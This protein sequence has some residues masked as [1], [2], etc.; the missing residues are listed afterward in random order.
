LVRNIET[1]VEEKPGE[2][3]PSN[4]ERLDTVT[5]HSE[6]ITMTTR[7]VTNGVLALLFLVVAVL[8]TSSCESKPNAYV[9]PDPVSSNL[10]KNFVLAEILQ[11]SRQIGEL[12][13]HLQGYRGRVDGEG[14]TY[15]GV[16]REAAWD[17]DY[18]WGGGRFGK[19]MDTLGM[20]G[21]FGRSADRPQPNSEE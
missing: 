16:K 5:S 18:G 6:A 14:D 17:M 7:K 8:S 15:P 10:N 1:L 12:A 13:H 4:G 11:D 20:A 3:I 2:H 9:K 21:R 19:R